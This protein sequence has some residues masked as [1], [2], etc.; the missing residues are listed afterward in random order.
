MQSRDKYTKLLSLYK[1]NSSMNRLFA[2]TLAALC[3]LLLATSCDM[4][5]IPGRME[6]LAA[7]VEKNGSSYS[8]DQWDK[9]NQKF[10][11]IYQE[12]KQKKGSLTQ[13]EIKRFRSATGRYATAAVKAGVDSVSA[14]IQEIGEELPGLLDEIGGFFKNLGESLSTKEGASE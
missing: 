4:F 2:L 8:Q 10:E 14:S 1:T 7:T 6:A 9:A 11:K 12:Y 3:A 5:S 13:D